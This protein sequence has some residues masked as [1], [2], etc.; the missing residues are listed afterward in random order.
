MNQRKRNG[1]C[2]KTLS[3]N[4]CREVCMHADVEGIVARIGGTAL[5]D[6]T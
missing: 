6:R 5:Y 3:D 2:S 4:C 1:G